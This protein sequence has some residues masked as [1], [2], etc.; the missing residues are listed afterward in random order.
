MC[1]FIDVPLRPHHRRSVVQS[2]SFPL[3]P[4]TTTVREKAKQILALLHDERRLYEER[5]AAA[6]N[7]RRFQESMSSEGRVSTSGYGGSDS[8]TGYGGGGG[9]YGGY[10]GGGD[11]GYG[12][13]GYGGGGGGGGGAG[14][15]GGNRYIGFG[16]D[17][18]RPP[19]GGSRGGSG[20]GGGGGYGDT[21]EPDYR[22]QYSSAPASRGEGG[23]RN[24]RSGARAR[25]DDTPHYDDAQYAH[26]PPAACAW[27]IPLL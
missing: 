10:G 4:T 16:S 12:G 24:G 3:R 26:A 18:V 8:Y 20:G 19:A 17:S 9:G 7:R 21:P 5:D 6:Q 11:T 22:A 15:A 2:A 23:S 25:Y 27:S 13:G 1:W 14:G